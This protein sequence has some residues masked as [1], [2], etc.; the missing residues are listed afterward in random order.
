M[1]HPCTWQEFTATLLT[2]AD[3][4]DALVR[5]TKVAESRNRKPTRAAF[6]VRRDAERR[7]LSP[8]FSS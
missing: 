1:F 4:I 7:G 6:S 3:E 2:F 8:C 5:R